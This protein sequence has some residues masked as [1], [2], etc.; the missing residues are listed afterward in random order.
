MIKQIFS[1]GI[2]NLITF[3]FTLITSFLIVRILSPTQIVDYYKLIALISWGSLTL[4][5]VNNYGIILASSENV[6]FNKIYIFIIQS[7]YSVIYIAILKIFFSTVP[8]ALFIFAIINFISLDWV[9]VAKNKP[10]ILI[11]GSIANKTFV[12]LALVLIYIYDSNFNCWFF[13]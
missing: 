5:A 8:V 3:F 7:I 2:L 9:F 13:T 4:I 10:N 1:G 11:V 12:A 6:R